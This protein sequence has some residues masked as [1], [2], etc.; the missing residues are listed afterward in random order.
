MSKTE[1]RVLGAD[2]FLPILIYV[3][4]KVRFYWVL[5][6]DPLCLKNLLNCSEL[7]FYNVIMYTRC[8]QLGL[9]CLQLKFYLVYYD[10]KN[11]QQLLK[12]SDKKLRSSGNPK[13]D[14]KVY[15]SFI[16]KTI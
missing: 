12:L 10:C 16:K 5:I 3:T 1:N 4:I 9:A 7:G 15:F 6:A 8:F 14:R 2:D 11:F 13:I